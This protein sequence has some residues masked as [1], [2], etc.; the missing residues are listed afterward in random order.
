MLMM[1]LGVPRAGK[2]YDAVERH[3]IKAVK[4]RRRVY[5]NI[6]GINKE[7]LEE[8]A[9]EEPLITEVKDRIMDVGRFV[10][11][12]PKNLPEIFCKNEEGE[13]VKDVTAIKLFLSKV[14]NRDIN[15]SV[16]AFKKQ[17]IKNPAMLLKEMEEVGYLQVEIKNRCRF[18]KLSMTFFHL[19]TGFVEP[20]LH[21]LIL[22]DEAQKAFGGVA[23]NSE[24]PEFLLSVLYPEADIT[25]EAKLMYKQDVSEFIAE[26]GHKYIDILFISQSFTSICKFIRQRVEQKTTF[27][28]LNSL[29]ADSK[30]QWVM[31]KCVSPEKFE[32]ISRGINSYKKEIFPV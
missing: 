7:V 12:Y 1:N 28:K 20:E 26:H 9:G 2:T 27:R 8:I 32:E 17:G 22:V 21:S 16:S 15:C 10:R 23:I 19:F 14:L 29:G 4:E 24:V 31:D 18:Y 11:K 6:Y 3:L 13:K 30:Y 25:S 5:T